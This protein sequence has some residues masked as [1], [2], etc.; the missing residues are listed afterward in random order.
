[1]TSGALLYFLYRDPHT[2]KVH[3]WMTSTARWE[4]VPG[5]RRPLPTPNDQWA[6]SKYVFV[7]QN[8]DSR[9][10]FVERLTPDGQMTNR[11]AVPAGL[12]VLGNFALTVPPESL[13]DSSDY[14]RMVGSQTS[15]LDVLFKQA[16][17]QPAKE[18][19]EV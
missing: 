17:W 8:D 7:R 16:G 13:A 18:M 5:G 6:Q 12:S 4:E 14:R 11:F 9:Q 2:D 3:W 15:P 19:A 10:V 1:M